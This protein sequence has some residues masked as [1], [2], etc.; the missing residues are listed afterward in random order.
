[1]TNKVVFAMLRQSHADTIAYIIISAV[2]GKNTKNH[3]QWL[4]VESKM[5]YGGE[6]R[7][8]KTVMKIIKSPPKCNRLEITHVD[9]RCSILV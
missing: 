3:D 1:M 2:S 5:H 7:W 4:T 8:S 9:T 6:L